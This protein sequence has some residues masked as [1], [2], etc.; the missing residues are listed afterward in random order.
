[1]KKF[2]CVFIF[3]FSQYISFGQAPL[4]TISIKEELLLI[5]DRDQ[6]TRTTKDSAA[7]MSYIDSCN[8]IQVSK[9][10]DTYG[11]LD[12]EVIGQK[13]NS[14]LFLVIQHSQLKVQEK[15]LP[16]LQASVKRGGSKPSNLA[17]L[18][19]RILMRK[20]LPQIYGSQVVFNKETGNQ[21]FYQIDDEVNV[22]ERRAKVGLMPIEEYAK[23]FGI[24]YIYSERK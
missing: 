8:L 2:I 1:M 7:F 24:E 9:I 13:A 6:K 15:Y 4:D 20:G 10:L 17:L 12:V 16:L 23:F 19:D 11:W 5:L 22:N 21:E 3:L 14:A 18:Q